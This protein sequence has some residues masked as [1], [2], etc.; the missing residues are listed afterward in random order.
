MVKLNYRSLGEGTPLVILHGLFGSLDNWATLS[1]KWAEEYHVFLVDLRN[2][3]KSPHTESH[4]YPEMAEDIH[5]FLEEHDLWN[6]NILGHSMGGKVAMQTALEFSDR[7]RSLIVADMAPKE[8]PRGHDEIF[9][10]MNAL[11]LEDTTRGNLEE[12][13]FDRLGDKGIVLFLSKNL[14]RTPSGFEWKFNKDVLE[15][16]Y[17]KILLPLNTIDTFDKPVLFV[18]GEKSGYLTEEDEKD[19]ERLF[20]NYQ[21]NIIENAGHWI[22]ADNPGRFYN[23]VSQ[24]LHTL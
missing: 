17:E 2:H 5:H 22:H 8:Y 12:Q 18:K 9:A 6:V 24:F 7:L 15:K 10:A 13:L 16:D 23:V 3:G 11:Q 21:L 20:P 1:R 4:S 19:I 14:K